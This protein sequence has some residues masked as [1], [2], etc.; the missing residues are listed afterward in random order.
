MPSGSRLTSCAASD[1]PNPAI[2][3][4]EIVGHLQNALAGSPQFALVA[5]DESI[6]SQLSTVAGAVHHLL[7][8]DLLLATTGALVAGADHL[9]AMRASA[10]V[11]A[12][13]GVDVEPS[14]D[15]GDGWNKTGGL[16]IRGRSDGTVVV[17]IDGGLDSP[18]AV[19]ISIEGKRWRAPRPR[20]VFPSGSASVLRSSGHREIG[21][22]MV[23][24]EARG[25]TLVRLDHVPVRGVL[26]DQLQTTD[27]FVDGP[28][29][30]FPPLRAKIL[31]AGSGRSRRTFDVL[32][33]DPDDGS[34]ELS[35][36]VEAGDRVQL[37]AFDPN[38]TD[39]RLINRVWSTRPGVDR[40]V[41]LDRELTVGFEGFDPIA[42]AVVR[43][44]S[45]AAAAAAGP[46]PWSTAA[47]LVIHVEEAD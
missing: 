10:V 39:E 34:V 26:V 30:E 36:A 9:D 27:A 1:H 44:S 37:I 23:A 33:V 3:V 14:P 11:W 28:S 16:E 22:P 35:G 2:A 13:C 41:L 46:E 38:L 45:T 7:G 12:I 4:G 15:D 25:R 19:F 8:P 24:T 40:G 42:T 18:P 43:Q 31:E 17:A 6:G 21:P 47:A 5:I 32:A 20:I 29:I